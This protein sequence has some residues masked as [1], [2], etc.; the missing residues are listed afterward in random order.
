[1]PRLP[2]SSPIAVLFFTVGVHSK[3]CTSNAPS[4]GSEVASLGFDRCLTQSLV[5]AW[6][7]NDEPFIREPLTLPTNLTNITYKGVSMPLKVGTC[8]SWAA[9]YTLT[10]SI[11]DILLREVL[12]IQTSLVCT[13]GAQHAIRMVGGCSNPFDVYGNC[14][15]SSGDPELDPPLAMIL[16]ETWITSPEAWETASSLVNILGQIGYY[17]EEVR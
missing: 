6:N 10:A 7:R 11:I 2:Q 14:T 4:P 13:F 5:D 17:Y 1:M 3:Y 8:A 16:G 9:G 15:T 12:G